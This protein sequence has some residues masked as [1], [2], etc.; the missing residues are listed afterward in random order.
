MGRGVRGCV[1]GVRG[2]ERVCKGWE[3]VCEGVRGVKR[4][5]GESAVQTLN[6]LDLL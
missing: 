4:E 6:W 1:R 3:R 5:K 2:C